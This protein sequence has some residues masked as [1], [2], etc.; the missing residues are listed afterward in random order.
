MS[1]VPALLQMLAVSAVTVHH[2]LLT[3][4]D[5]QEA[6]RQHSTDS[7]ANIVHGKAQ[8]LPKMF[9]KPLPGILSAHTW[10]CYNNANLDP[11]SSCFVLGAAHS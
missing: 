11:H 2:P 10:L 4:A 5:L 1:A 6:S 9:L 3:A 8:L 7:K